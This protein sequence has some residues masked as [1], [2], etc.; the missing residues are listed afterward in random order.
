MGQNGSDLDGSEV[1]EQLLSL[2]HGKGSRPR[3]F[4]ILA[5]DIAQGRKGSQRQE[6]IP[7]PERETHNA[8]LVVDHDTR[9]ASR[10]EN[11]ENFPN[12]RLRVGAVVNH[13]PGIYDIK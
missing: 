5:I 3:A 2:L 7:D 8:Q 11:A 4:E 1:L 6:G 12:S 13:S 10:H 9:L